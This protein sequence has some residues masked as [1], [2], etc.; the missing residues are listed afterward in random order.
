MNE[1]KIVIKEED[2]ALLVVELEISTETAVSVLTECKGS[3]EKA[4]ATFIE[5]APVEKISE[6]E[7][8]GPA[9]SSSLAADVLVT[10]PVAAATDRTAAAPPVSLEDEEDEGW[11]ED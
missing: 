3:V 8:V 5:S 9:P 7:K 10:A 11:D 4:L 6:S 1:E 2:V